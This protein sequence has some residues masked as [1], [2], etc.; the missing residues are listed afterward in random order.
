MI[1]VKQA[2]YCLKAESNKYEEECK[3]CELY[4]KK[5][6]EKCYEEAI[7]KIIEFIDTNIKD[8]DIE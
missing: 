4:N 2:I 7:D 1:T 8:K 5:G 3:E 6:N